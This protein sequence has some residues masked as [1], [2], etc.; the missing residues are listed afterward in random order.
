MA[1]IRMAG[2]GEKPIVMSNGAI[3]LDTSDA[4]AFQTNS[5]IV[6]DTEESK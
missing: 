1:K 5:T 3:V 4:M 6:L 2:A